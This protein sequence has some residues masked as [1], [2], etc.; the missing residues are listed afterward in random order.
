MGVVPAKIEKVEDEELRLLWE[1]GHETLLSFRRLRQVCPCALCRDEWTGRPL[2]DPET[3]PVDLKGPRVE[4][5]GNYA[6][7]FQFSDGHAQGIYTFDMLRR[8]CACAACAS[9]KTNA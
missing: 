5:V 2:I 8:L 4:I 3:V 7:A 1:D 6:L 9:R